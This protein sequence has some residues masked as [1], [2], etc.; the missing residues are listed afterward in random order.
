L[1]D[2]YAVDRG[3][4][5]LEPETTDTY[6]L[7]WR[8][9]FSSAGLAFEA[10]LF[11]IDADDFIE[12]PLTG[13]LVQNFEAYQF[14]GRGGHPCEPLIGSLRLDRG[15]TWTDSENQS[16]GADIETLQNRPEHKFALRA[17]YEFAG[18][19]RVGGP[20]STSP[21]ATPCRARRRPRAQELGD[22]NVLDLDVSFEFGGNARVYARIENALDELYE[23]SFG[24][25]QAGRHARAGA[26]VRL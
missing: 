8:Q 18:G 15:H 21:T 22:Y 11:H 6:E 2:L 7:G 17:D 20:G 13:G 10:V 3:N 12:R 5:E 26:E 25:P 16:S 19:W 14:P 24:F 23:E 1:R 4:P 9:D